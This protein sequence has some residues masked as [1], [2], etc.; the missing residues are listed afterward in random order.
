VL[1]I[2]QD[3][4][5][6]G[7][8]IIFST[9]IM[10]EAEKICDEIAIIERGSILAKGNLDSLRREHG[11]GSLEDVFVSTVEKVTPRKR[12]APGSGCGHERE[13]LGGVP[14]GAARRHAR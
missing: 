9:H 10:T 2:V 7:R 5:S 1:R 4:K 6:K 8:T 11:G 14:E 12:G 3:L 13:S